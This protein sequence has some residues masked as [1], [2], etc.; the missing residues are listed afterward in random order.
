MIPIEPPAGPQ[1]ARP[2]CRL[3]Q[4]GPPRGVSDDDC[5]TAPMLIQDSGTP[6]IPGYPQG[7]ANYAYFKPTDAELDKLRDGGFIEFA[8]YG[9]VVQPFSALVWPADQPAGKDD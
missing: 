4:M 3:V 2:W 9:P 6:P 7:R 1:A 5:G 8:Q